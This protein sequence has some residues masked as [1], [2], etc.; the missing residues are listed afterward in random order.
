MVVLHIFCDRD[1]SISMVVLHIFCDSKR[2]AREWEG[3]KRHLA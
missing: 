1:R 3:Q 2:D